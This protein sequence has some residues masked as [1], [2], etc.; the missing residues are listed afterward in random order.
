MKTTN[1]RIHKHTKVRR[2]ISN[3]VALSKWHDI[4][5]INNNPLVQ[6]IKRGLE[7][8]LYCWSTLQ[9]M[10]DWEI[11]HMPPAKNLYKSNLFKP[12]SL[13]ERIT[14]KIRRK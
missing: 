12:K 4:Y 2:P 5:G 14:N 1:I 10:Y 6:D 3:Y 11:K 8:P 9:E 13:L 7:N